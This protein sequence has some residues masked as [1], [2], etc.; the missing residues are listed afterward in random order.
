[1]KRV[2]LQ[3]PN[4]G[5]VWNFLATTRKALVDV[6]EATVEGWF[7]DTELELASGQ[8]GAMEQAY[9]VREEPTPPVEDIP[10]AT[11][12]ADKGTPVELYGKSGRAYPGKIFTK[13]SGAV[14]LTSPALICLA[15]SEFANGNWQHRVNA[16]YATDNAEQER[17]RFT[18]RDDVSHLIV[19]PAE[20]GSGVDA[21]DDLIRSY[22]HR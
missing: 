5:E 21:T 17:E 7:T 8:F 11:P 3:F 10:P 2:K 12:A 16:I 20:E 14:T 13:A 1:M 15:N 9:T 22:L 4:T 19:V 6:D 18:Q